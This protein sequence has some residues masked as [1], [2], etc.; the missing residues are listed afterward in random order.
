MGEEESE[1]LCVVA[2]G[3][4]LYCDSAYSG[5]IIPVRLTSKVQKKKAQARNQRQAT[6]NTP[7]SLVLSLMNR[8]DAE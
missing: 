1:G 7:P 4:C 2:A 8:M 3:N 6:S 5:C